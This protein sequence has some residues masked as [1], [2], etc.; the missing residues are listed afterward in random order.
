VRFIAKE[1]NSKEGKY[2]KYLEC[3]LRKLWKQDNPLKKPFNYNIARWSKQ[4]ERFQ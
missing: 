4:E 2:N 1:P 3:D